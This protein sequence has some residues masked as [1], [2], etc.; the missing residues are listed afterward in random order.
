[1]N[2]EVNLCQKEEMS[3]LGLCPCLYGGVT[4]VSVGT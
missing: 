1:M 3:S 4:S 2:Q